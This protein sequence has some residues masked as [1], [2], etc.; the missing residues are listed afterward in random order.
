MLFSGPG[1]ELDLLLQFPGLYFLEKAVP[2]V[3]LGETLHLVKL[4]GVV[5]GAGVGAGVLGFEFEV[6]LM[7]AVELYG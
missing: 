5:L 2:H 4:E 6:L 7:K 1:D 3:D